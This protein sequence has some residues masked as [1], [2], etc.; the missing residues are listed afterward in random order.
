MGF[1]GAVI[2]ALWLWL[3]AGAPAVIAQRDGALR[4]GTF[5]V[6]ATTPS[7]SSPTPVAEEPAMAPAGSMPAANSSMNSTVGINAT[8]ALN[9]TGGTGSVDEDLDAEII[10]N[11]LGT[12]QEMGEAD[13]AQEDERT[14]P[15]DVPP[16]AEAS[17]PSTATGTIDPADQA[18]SGDSNLIPTDDGLLTVVRPSPSPAPPVA[19]GP[20][21]SRSPPFGGTTLPNSSSASP[22]A[23]APPLRLT[24]P[25]PGA[26]PSPAPASKSPSSP[27]AQSPH[28]APSPQLAKP[29]QLSLPSRGAAPPQ[30]ALS[31]N[32]APSPRQELSIRQAVVPEQFA[33]SPGAA[34]TLGE[35]AEEPAEGPVALPPEAILVAAAPVSQM[36]VEDMEVTLEVQ[37]AISSG[38]PSEAAE[39]FVETETVTGVA[40]G[41]RAPPEFTVEAFPED[42]PLQ[43]KDPDVVAAKGV[44]IAVVQ[45]IDSDPQIV[46]RMADAIIE[47][48]LPKPPRRFCTTGD[49]NRPDWWY[50]HVGGTRSDWTRNSDAKC[51]GSVTFN[52]VGWG[53]E[54]CVSGS[55]RSECE[56]SLNIGERDD[57]L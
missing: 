21:P 32:A 57:A 8:G 30:G 24:G 23:T 37:M 44:A 13:A 46:E 16:P 41:L 15:V 40:D 11:A 31:P 33:E 49:P 45:A 1:R 34:P 6:V 39:V 48:A 12:P 10:D 52:P 19:L 26:A 35:F 50:A 20:S 25:P 5:T 17:G 3:W 18:T 53:E 4:T 55:T 42:A 9:V 29:P 28:A 54:P 22:P 7:V 38:D 14:P 27:V 36:Q 43:E 2:A 47:S 56:R 51:L